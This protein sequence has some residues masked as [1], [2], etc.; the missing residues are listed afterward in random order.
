MPTINW[1]VRQDGTWKGWESF[2]G[3]NAAWECVD[4]SDTTTHDSG[5]SRITLPRLNLAAGLGRISFPIP[6]HGA[7]ALTPV[8]FVVNVAAV[9]GGATHPE[10]AIGFYRSDGIGFSAS[11]FNPGAAYSVATRTFTTD[12]IT[13]AAWTESGLVGLEV[14]L[15]S[16][17]VAAGNNDI[18]LIS[19]SLTY[20]GPTNTMRRTDRATGTY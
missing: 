2:V 4:D 3:G 15:Q 20:H 17:T 19:G 9:R 1:T 7:V 8:S 12:P 5:A 6:L 13:G 14:C 16:E 11:L 18:S 10:I